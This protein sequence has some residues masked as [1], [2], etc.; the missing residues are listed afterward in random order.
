MTG[1]TQLGDRIDLQC[2]S[3]WELDDPTKSP[4][5]CL[6]YS[7]KGDWTGEYSPDP[8]GAPPLPLSSLSSSLALGRGRECH[9]CSAMLGRRRLD[10]SAV[11]VPSHH[12]LSQSSEK[13]TQCLACSAKGDWAGEY[14]P[15]HAGALPLPLTLP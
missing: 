11:S 10:G 12:L 13:D 8:S 14:S 2:D 15:P 4:A 7:A 5:D 6:A 9:A 3:G 1:P